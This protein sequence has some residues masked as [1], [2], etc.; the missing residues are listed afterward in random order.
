MD[1]KTDRIRLADLHEIQSPEESH[2][3]VQALMARLMDIEPKEMAEALSQLEARQEFPYLY[4]KSPHFTEDQDDFLYSEDLK[5]EI[6][7]IYLDLAKH[8]RQNSEGSVDL[9]NEVFDFFSKTLSAL[10]KM[11]YLTNNN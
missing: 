11:P 9:M 5:K 1:E 6:Q 2:P 8:L 3:E 4:I 10:V 7:T